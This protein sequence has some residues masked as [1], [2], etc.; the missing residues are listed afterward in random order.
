MAQATANL[1][2]AQLALQA[3][4]QVFLNLNNSSLLNV[5]TAAGQ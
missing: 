2:Q 4:S 5:L 3:S 1:Q